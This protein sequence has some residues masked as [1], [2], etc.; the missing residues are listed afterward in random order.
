[1]TVAM[2]NPPMVDITPDLVC[3]VGRL[4]L[5]S[6]SPWLAARQATATGGRRPLR[7]IPSMHGRSW[8]VAA[9]TSLLIG[10]RTA[11]RVPPLNAEE[12]EDRAVAKSTRVENGGTT[13]SGSWPEGRRCRMQLRWQDRIWTA[14]RLQLWG[15]RNNYFC[16]LCER[17][18]ETSLHL[19]I[20]CPYSRKV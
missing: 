17:L 8:L 3:L 11:T 1:M 19:F 6:S 12:G 4:P 20:E 18:L 10:N 2:L 9:R 5:L 14:A 16:A 13:T 15:W 7:F